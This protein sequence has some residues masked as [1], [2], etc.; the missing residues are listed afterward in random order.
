ML[1]GSIPRE[2]GNMSTLERLA[3]DTNRLTGEHPLRTRVVVAA[4]MVAVDEAIYLE[5]A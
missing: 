4:V 5:K 1:T 2:L 3:L